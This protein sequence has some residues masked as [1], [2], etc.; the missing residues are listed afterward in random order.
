VSWSWSLWLKEQITNQSKDKSTKSL[1]KDESVFYLS[2][3][4]TLV[5]T[6]VLLLGVLLQQLQALDTVQEVKSRVRVLDVLNTQV[7]TLWHDAVSLNSSIIQ[8]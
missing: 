6:D 3:E 1:Y 8:I 2:L 7:D 5:Q 4:L